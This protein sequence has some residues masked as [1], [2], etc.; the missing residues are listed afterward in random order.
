MKTLVFNS[1]ITSLPFIVPIIDDSVRE[2]TEIF[3]ATLT[4]SDVP[5]PGFDGVMIRPVIVNVIIND[6]DC[7]RVCSFVQYSNF[8]FSFHSYCL[9]IDFFLPYFLISFNAFSFCS[10]LQT[11]LSFIPSSIPT[12][13]LPFLFPPSLFPRSSSFLPPS[14]DVTIGFEQISYTI[15]EDIGTLEVVVRTMEMLAQ[16]VIVTL[17]TKDGTAVCEDSWISLLPSS[18]FLIIFCVY[19]LSSFHTILCILYLFLITQC[20]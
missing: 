7:K 19:L 15:S 13:S 14:S 20:F 5:N 4:K 10:L 11:S 2:E 16:P 3:H 9:P 18:L 6:N 1:S 8:L 12:F 17:T